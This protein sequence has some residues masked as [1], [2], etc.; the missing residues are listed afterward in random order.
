MLFYHAKINQLPWYCAIEAESYQWD[1]ART[2]EL[3]AVFDWAGRVNMPLAFYHLDLYPCRFENSLELQ[4]WQNS[5]L[6][7]QIAFL[8]EFAN[9]GHHRTFLCAVETIVL[10]V[11]RQQAADSGL[12]GRLGEDLCQLV[13]VDDREGLRQYY[14]FWKST[15]PCKHR[16]KSTLSRAWAFLLANDAYRREVD[17]WLVKLEYVLLAAVWKTARANEHPSDASLDGVFPPHEHVNFPI[18]DCHKIVET[19]PWVIATREWL[20]SVL[21]R[22]CFRVCWEPRCIDYVCTSM[23]AKKWRKVYYSPRRAQV[24]VPSTRRTRSCMQKKRWARSGLRY[25]QRQ[26]KLPRTILRRAK[27]MK[28]VT[29]SDDIEQ[30]LCYLFSRDFRATD[31]K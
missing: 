18:F 17:D 3:A 22:I 5:F 11:T 29:Y 21:P 14:Q 24:S 20:P 31:K 8:N 23:T 12:F 26:K 19:H 30:S 13:D 16:T 4:D 10:H 28:D 1:S 9:Q 7:P 15:S 6:A 2:R 27:V 25:K